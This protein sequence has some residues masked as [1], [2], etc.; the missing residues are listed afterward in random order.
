M[1]LVGGLTQHEALASSPVLQ[2]TDKN[3]VEREETSSPG[4]VIGGD[5]ASGTRSG[6]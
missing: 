1:A 2:K 6:S 5:W 4:Y 3:D